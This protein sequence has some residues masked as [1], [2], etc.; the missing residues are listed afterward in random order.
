ML[1]FIEDTPTTEEV[2]YRGRTFRV[3]DR[4][5]QRNNVRSERIVEIRN[6]REMGPYL[7]T[8]LNRNGIH[9]GWF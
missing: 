3:G 7:I 4:V 5:T 8:T 2:E 1:K 6:T 9:A